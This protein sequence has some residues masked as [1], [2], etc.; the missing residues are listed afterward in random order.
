MNE[1]CFSNG[2]MILEPQANESE[3]AFENDGFLFCHVLEHIIAMHNRERWD[4]LDVIP[5]ND[6]HKILKLDQ[7]QEIIVKC[8]TPV[9]RS[10][11]GYRGDKHNKRTPYTQ[12]AL[13]EFEEVKTI[14]I[15]FTKKTRPKEF[16]TLQSIPQFMELTQRY[17]KTLSMLL[18]QCS[19]NIYPHHHFLK[20]KK[21][22]DG[23]KL[24]QVLKMLD[25]QTGI[26]IVAGAPYYIIPD[27]DY[28]AFKFEKKYVI[29]S[30][31]RFWRSKSQEER[32]YKFNRTQK[33]LI[34]IEHNHDRDYQRILDVQKHLPEEEPESNGI[35]E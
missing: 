26:L 23:E 21:K 13:E 28:R 22:D 33:E 5:R 27:T 20:Y 19:Y 17:Q 12:E 14:D 32:E 29:A 4:D 7:I 34:A 3:Y 15:S 9:S 11:S 35:G 31:Y 6:L 18:S 8:I 10:R 24:K 30:G 1:A 16:E 25:V 2:E